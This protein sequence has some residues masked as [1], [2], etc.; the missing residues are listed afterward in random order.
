MVAVQISD[1][2][3]DPDSTPVQVTEEE[4]KSIQGE[5]Q[6]LIQDLIVYLNE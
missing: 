2:L 4:L 3:F 5:E 1:G 6:E